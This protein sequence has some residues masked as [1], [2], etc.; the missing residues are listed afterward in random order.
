MKYGFRIIA[1]TLLVTSIFAFWWRQHHSKNDLVAGWT[2]TNITP[3]A[4][5][6]GTIRYGQPSPEFNVSLRD[7]EVVSK[8]TVRAQEKR[9]FELRVSPQADH[10]QPLPFPTDVWL[11]LNERPE[12]TR[13]IPFGSKPGT[14]ISM[15][16]FAIE[17]N[18][19][20]YRVDLSM[21]GQPGDY[22]I[23][24]KVEYQIIEAPEGRLGKFHSSI[25]KSVEVLLHVER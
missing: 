16:P 12:R 20:I 19:L 15:I 2:P 23:C 14:A 22:K 25:A 11:T 10:I 7:V 9:L 17:Q 8:P 24:G 3:P 13:M 6:F 1:I 4:F 5:G 21:P 18:S